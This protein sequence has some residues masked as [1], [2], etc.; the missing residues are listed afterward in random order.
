MHA[1]GQET[2]ATTKMATNNI[3]QYKHMYV[4]YKLFMCVGC[5]RGLLSLYTV[6]YMYIIWYY[7]R[8]SVSKNTP[9]CN[10]PKNS[11]H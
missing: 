3:F 1:N 5:A 4:Y 10:D 6:E 11:E 7:Y 9:Q 2:S 8:R